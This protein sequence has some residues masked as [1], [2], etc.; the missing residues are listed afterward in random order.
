LENTTICTE[1]SF[2]ASEICEIIRVCG[3]AG[4]SFFS[5]KGIKVCFQAREQ[6][7]GVTDNYN[8]S[9]PTEAIAQNFSED[10]ITQDE[11][12]LKEDEISGLHLSDPVLYEKLLIE[13]DLID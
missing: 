12:N 6:A 1:T 4:V 3:T 9:G 10:L 5:C 2:T 13:R 11:I 8:S 7:V